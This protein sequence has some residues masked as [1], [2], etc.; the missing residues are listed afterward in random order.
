MINDT[1]A[2]HFTADPV[3]GVVGGLVVVAGLIMLL[4][5]AVLHFYFT[6]SAL[7]SG[8]I[9]P[10]LGAAGFCCALV[11]VYLC[12]RNATWRLD[13][14]KTAVILYDPRK[15]LSQIFPYSEYTFHALD[16]TG[17]I[18]LGGLIWR[19]SLGIK[20][21]GTLTPYA[22]PLKDE[23]VAGFLLPTIINRSKECLGRR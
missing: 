17:K 10:I 19:P 9:G 14:A 3:N 21:G 4:V 8:V 23:A 1:D 15:R 12:W 20:K 2:I 11:G 13:V 16:T 6:S 18:T 7:A 22:V 5:G